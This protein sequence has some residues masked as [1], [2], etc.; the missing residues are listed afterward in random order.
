MATSLFSRPSM[1]TFRGVGLPEDKGRKKSRGPK[2]YVASTMTIINKAI[3]SCGDPAALKC[4]SLLLEGLHGTRQEID[5]VVQ[6]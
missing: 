5:E 2:G 3:R 6:R 1:H 4:R